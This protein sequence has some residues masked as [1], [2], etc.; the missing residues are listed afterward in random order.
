MHPSQLYITVPH[1]ELLL[2]A[3]KSTNL[4]AQFSSESL[5]SNAADQLPTLP[6]TQSKYAARNRYAVLGFIYYGIKILMRIK[7]EIIL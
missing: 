4:M 7:K 6:K 3:I 1:N 2:S 5:L